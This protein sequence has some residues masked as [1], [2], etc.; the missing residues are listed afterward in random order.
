MSYGPNQ[1]E[2]IDTS[3]GFWSLILKKPWKEWGI[4][5]QGMNVGNTLKTGFSAIKNTDIF[6]HNHL[7]T[8]TITRQIGKIKWMRSVIGY[9]KI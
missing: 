2:K 8:K 9:M 1:T 7:A 4:H 6:S 5:S 3:T